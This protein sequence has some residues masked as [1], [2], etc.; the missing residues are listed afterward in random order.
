M[1]SIKYIKG[2]AT[3]DDPD[4]HLGKSQKGPLFLLLIS[5]RLLVF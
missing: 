2:A 1:S 5:F 4:F 3:K